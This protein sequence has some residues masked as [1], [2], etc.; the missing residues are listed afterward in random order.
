MA[1]F[2]CFLCCAQRQVTHSAF[3]GVDV[4]GKERG[5]SVEACERISHIFYLLLALFRLEFGRYFLSPLFWQPPAPVRCDSP[6]KLL[7]EFRLF[8]T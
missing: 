3:F 8:S 7:D 6:R 1:C 2:L 4:L 5:C